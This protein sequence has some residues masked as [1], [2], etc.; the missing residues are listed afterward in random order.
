MG[1][2]A[3]LRVLNEGGSTE[4][5]KAV[6]EGEGEIE[7]YTVDFGSLITTHLL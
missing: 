2:T 5:I 4:G 3:H 7:P 1:R 6:G